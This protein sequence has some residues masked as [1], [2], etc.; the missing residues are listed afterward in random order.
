MGGSR[1]GERCDPLARGRGGSGA[2]CS[3]GGPE[4]GEA[5][6]G[7]GSL[8]LGA[9]GGGE[10]G[11]CLLDAFGICLQRRT[12][13]KGRQSGW[14]HLPQWPSV[15]YGVQGNVFSGTV[16]GTG[17]GLDRGSARPGLSW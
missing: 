13:L 7:E 6:V 3:C 11:E 8:L 14:C 16:T 5:A 15:A 12:A 9:A 17:S 1:R 10:G 4:L 2:G